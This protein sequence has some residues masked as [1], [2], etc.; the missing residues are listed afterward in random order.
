M[1]NLKKVVS[2]LV[3]AVMLS[4]SAMPAVVLAQD[5]GEPAQTEPAPTPEPTPEPAPAPAPAPAPEPTPEPEPTGQSAPTGVIPRYAFNEQTGKWVPTNQD[6]FRWDNAIK[7]YVSPLYRYQTSNGWYY[8]I[9]QPAPAPTPTSAAATSPAGGSGGS[10]A[11]T[12]QEQASAYAALASLL[13]L[14]D[15]LNRNTGPNSTNTSTLNN[16]A[17][18][19]FNIFSAATVNNDGTS[20]ATSGDASVSG[21]AQ[22]GN[23]TTGMSTVLANFLNLINS[24]WGWSNGSLSYFLGNFFGDRTGDITLNP[25]QQAGG[26]GSI[27]C[28]FCFGGSLNANENTGAD[29]TNTATTN[30]DRDLTVN[31]QPN[32]TINNDVNLIAQSGNADVNGNT[33][34]GNATSGD[35]IVELNIINM[36]NSAIS[37]G[38]SFFGLLNIF[39][40]LNGDI[41]FPSG[42]LTGALSGAGGYGSQVSNSNTG[43]ESTNT[44]TSNANFNGTINDNSNA[45]F[46]NN[47]NTGAASGSADVTSNTRAG[48]ATTGEAE[49]NTN[50]YNLYNAGVRGSNAVLVLV[51]V[52]GT[53]VG[54][55]MDVPNAGGNS[56]ALLGGNAVVGNSNTGPN[57]TNTA[58][59][60]AN[61]SL[62]VNYAPTSTINNNINAG[63]ISGDAG[64]NRNT[65]GGN[66]TSGDAKVAANVVNIM[67]SNIDLTNW[68]GVLVIN[69]FGNWFGSV[70]KDTS[71]GTLGV[72]GSTLALSLPSSATTTKKS[73]N[74]STFSPLSINSNGTPLAGG[75]G[76]SASSVNDAGTKIKLASAS[77]VARVAAAKK[78][79][80]GTSMLFILTAVVLL[81]SGGM[82]TLSRR[83]GR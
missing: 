1:I 82:L 4:I 28:Y 83:L 18:A 43:P 81:G 73:N 77:N 46:N 50:T 71:A 9:P 66:A 33:V 45:T 16:E 44:A 15:P 5:T 76:G 42:F 61:A 37:S 65:V 55:I 59:N 27:G 64:V 36:I 13:G 70:G 25:E 11:P 63:A 67:G 38:G 68:F 21:N 26:G 7:R 24:A 51:N 2:S 22:A 30:G 20:A 57:S 19:L 6:S 31:Y 53:W 80:S 62:D 35:A 41:L 8:V 39:G 23:A 29:S 12:Q 54:L 10:A 74:S 3:L 47:L 72:G 79:A 14:S 32:G 34:G 49:T 17:S 60:N 75:T 58:T 69:V 52:L 56:S 78:S 48:N 40:D